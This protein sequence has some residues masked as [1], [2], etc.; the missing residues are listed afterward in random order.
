MV[1]VLHRQGD[2]IVGRMD[3]K[4]LVSESRYHGEE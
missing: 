2:T 1:V 4:V 3:G